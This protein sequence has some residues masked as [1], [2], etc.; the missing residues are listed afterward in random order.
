MKDL[1]QAPTQPYQHCDACFARVT[2]DDTYCAGC[3]YPLK[4]S[5]NEQKKFIDHRNKN[6]VNLPKFKK[7][8]A[9]AGNTLY[10]LSAVFILY[11]AISFFTSSNDPYILAI[12]I[13]YLILAILFLILGSF[14]NQKPLACF[15]S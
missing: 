13:P 4:G 8:V 15:I 9:R 3:G 5:E 2:D 1:I 6:D 7:K 12:V 10:Y 11:S 14:S